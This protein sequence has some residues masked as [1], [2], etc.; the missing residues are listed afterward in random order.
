MISFEYTKKNIE[1]VKVVHQLLLASILL[2]NY[3]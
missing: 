1:Q 2:N 3:I